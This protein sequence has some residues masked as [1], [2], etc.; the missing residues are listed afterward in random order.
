MRNNLPVLAQSRWLRFGV[1]TAY[2]VLQGLPWGLNAIALPAWLFGQGMGKESIASF[3]AIT[4]LPWALKLFV[5]PL[6]DRFSFLPMGMRRP[7]IIGAQSLMLLT[8]SFLFFI[9]DPLEQFW[10]LL[11]ICT[12]LNIFA[13]TEDVAVDGLAIA[14]VPENER[15]RANAFMGAGQ[16]IGISITGSAAVALLNWRGLPA[17]AM[18]LMLTIG[19]LVIVSILFRERLGERFLPWSQ[20]KANSDVVKPE[21]SI[22][23]LFKDLIQVL[24]LPMSLLVMGVISL[25]RINYGLY[26]VWAPD[27]AI[28]VLSYSDSNYANW[29]ATVSLISAFCGLALGPVI[30]KL[31]THRAYTFTLL[32]AACLYAGLFPF[33]DTMIRPEIAVV[34]LF[35]VYL[36]STMLF[37]TFISLAMSLCRIELA[38]TQFAFY[39]A[40][41]NLGM[42]LGSALYP[43]VFDL[44]GMKTILLALGGIYAFA[45][46]LM[47]RFDPATHKIR[48]SKLT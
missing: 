30:D 41:A 11:A 46:L 12:V 1:F 19:L 42:S 13:A 8:S 16:V 3:A 2:Y 24:I 15:G 36:T 43:V 45:W 32:F 17:V 22:L 29:V 4:G 39:M 14:I 28:N 34:A 23:T 9:T 33:M 26:K 10:W 27:L 35:L 31:G 47:G 6:M 44:L 40:L 37:I 7:W 25:Q 38:S 18:F 5:A 21:A 48:L 20:G